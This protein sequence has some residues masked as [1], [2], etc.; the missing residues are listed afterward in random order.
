MLSPDLAL[1]LLVNRTTQAYVTNPPVYMTYVERTHVTAPTLGRSQDINRSVAVRVADDLALMQDLPQGA[2]R[3]GPAF[4]IIPYF[5]PLSSFGFSYFANLKSINI[6]LVRGSPI[7]FPI[8]SPDPNI[9]VLF[10]YI[11]FWAPRYAP[12]STETALHFL[13]DP[14]PKMTAFYPQ[15][16]I[17]DPTTQLPS[18][19]VMRDTGSDMAIALDYKVIAGHW[20]IVH[21]VFSATE[22]VI[23][24]FPVIA[25][26]TFSQIAFPVAAPFAQ[27]QAPLPAPVAASPTPRP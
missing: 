8:P 26:V 24:A 4:P 27:L 18:R 1:A 7:E 16:I 19:I 13:L 17:E 12:D 6:N 2:Q 25:D 11:S 20:V 5:D 22:H 10:P 3:T 15:E 23:V 9:D 14:T 21:G